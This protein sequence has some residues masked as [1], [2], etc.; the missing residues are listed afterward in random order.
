MYKIIG[1]DGKEYGPVTAEQLRQW[2]AENRVNA[3]T[4]VQA[5]NS[6]DWKPL[7]SY[8]EF[9]PAAL[10]APQAVG[11]V[12]GETGPSIEELTARDYHIGIGDCLS[13]GWKLVKANLGLLVGGTALV[14]VLLGAIQTPG[15]IGRILI[16]TGGRAHPALLITGG[17]LSLIGGLAAMVL[18]G[19]LMGG[20]YWPYL[21]LLRSQ[22]VTISDFFAGFRR[23]FVNLMLFQIVV[24]LLLAALIL[25]PMITVAIGAAMHFAKHAPGGIVTM[26]IG[27][28]LLLVT[29]PIMIYLN[30]CWFFALPLAVD[31]RLGFW[32]AMKL[33]KCKVRQHWWQVFGLMC[34]AGLVGVAGLLLCC[35]GVLFTSPIAVA[36]FMCAYEVIFG[37]LPPTNS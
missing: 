22:P 11:A 4:A 14:F 31:R 12:A 15:T 29:L 19:P 24:S 20:L 32:E 21:R 7:G 18:T 8:P 1:T 25:P 10:S 5:E 37:S 6:P 9:G 16:N 30:T 3:Q 27:G 35:V 23:G 33:S 26:V 2:L 36:S 13:A 17:L 34:V 28:T